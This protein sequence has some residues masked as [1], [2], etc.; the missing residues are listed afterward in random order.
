MNVEFISALLSIF[1]SIL[2]IF[3][4]FAGTSAR[5]HPEAIGIRGKQTSIVINQ[6]KVSSINKLYYKTV[7][8]VFAPSQKQVNNVRKEKLNLS[9]K[10]EKIVIVPFFLGLILLGTI[11]Q[12][13]IYIA[14]SL[15]LLFFVYRFIRYIKAIVLYIHAGYTLDSNKLLGFKFIHAFQ[16]IVIFSLALM[17][18]PNDFLKVVTYVGFDLNNLQIGLTTFS[19]WFA[20]VVKYLFIEEGLGNGMYFFIRTAGFL[21]LFLSIIITT[22]T[23]LNEMPLKDRNQVQSVLDKLKSFARIVLPG[24]FLLTI[25]LATL[26]PWYTH[27]IFLVIVEPISEWMKN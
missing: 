11:V 18:L 24:I 3:T 17:P 12:K 1:A 15:L 5:K 21:F 7:N 13:H 20:D 6:N 19:G 2:T 27:S 26:Y 4:V 14:I 23:K 22:S 10:D 9:S 25:S 16:L 8:L